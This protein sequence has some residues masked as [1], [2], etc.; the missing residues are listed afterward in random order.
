MSL[1]IGTIT[2]EPGEKKNGMLCTIQDGPELPITVI[3]GKKKGA[4]VLISA[5]V[6]GAEYSGIQ[7]AMELSREIDPEEV[8][9]NL[10][11]LLM[12]NPQASR[13]FVRFVVPEDNKNLNRV[14][15]GKKD[16]SLSERTAYAMVHDLMSQADYYID[17]H[18]GDTSERVMPFVYYPG[19]AR[20]EVT[21]RAKAMAMAANLA[22]RVKSTAE[23][24]KS[25][26]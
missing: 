2:A 9:G 26:V 4:T 14:F 22:V 15:P 5:G 17:L 1:Q 25:V 21:E 12:A 16:G 23:D 6:H 3:C 18:A 13:D 7:T 8:R 20:E 19:K 10:I 11:F 24:R